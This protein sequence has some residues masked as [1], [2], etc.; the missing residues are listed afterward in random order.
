MLD[1]CPDEYSVE[2]AL[3]FLE[4]KLK[5]FAGG[6]V[7]RLS[8]EEDLKKINIKILKKDVLDKNKIHFFFK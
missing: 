2:N 5:T 1:T 3:G 6:K 4:E 8:L 7:L